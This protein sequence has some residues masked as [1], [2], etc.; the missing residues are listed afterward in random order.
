[1]GETPRSPPYLMARVLADGPGRS[2]LGNEACHPLPKYSLCQFANYSFD[3][4]DSFLWNGVPGIG[5]FSTTDYKTKMKLEG[6]ESR[7]V[8]GVISQ[9]PIEQLRASTKNWVG[10]LSQ[11]TV[12]NDF[13]LAKQ[14][15]DTMSFMDTIPDAETGYKTGLAYRAKFPFQVFDIIQIT[16]VIVSILWLVYCSGSLIR[17][18]IRSKLLT[19]NQYCSVLW[20]TAYIACLSTIITN[21]A[22]CGVLSGVHDRYQARVMWLVPALALLTF[23]ADQSRARANSRIFRYTL[24]PGNQISL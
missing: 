18:L 14:S 21:A 3:T 5:V 2:Y 8:I 19:A 4:Q 7:F 23:F 20:I 12:G 15:W 9:Y 24:W 13:R 10:A 22:M 17:I 11:F 6:E 1:M 16:V